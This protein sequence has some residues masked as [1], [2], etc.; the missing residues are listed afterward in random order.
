MTAVHFTDQR[1]NSINKGSPLTTEERAF[2]LE[3]TPRF[4]ECVH[5][6]SDLAEMSDAAL[7]RAAINTWADYARFM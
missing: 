7:M 2:L 6:P 5:K 3:D 4:E 1:I